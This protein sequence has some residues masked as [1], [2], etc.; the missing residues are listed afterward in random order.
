MPAPK[1]N[2]NALGCQTSGRPPKYDLIQEAKDL[3]EFSKQES[4]WTLEDFTDDKEYC[5]SELSYFAKRSIEFSKA[6]K[7][8]KE[9]I[10]IGCK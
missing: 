6:L 10:S 3:L 9:R 8:A 4:C 5:A 7:K 1:G 2:K